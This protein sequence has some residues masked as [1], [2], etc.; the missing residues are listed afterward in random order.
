MVFRT[1]VKILGP[2]I[3]GPLK[4]LEKIAALWSNS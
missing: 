1:Y 3:I 2:P 4:E